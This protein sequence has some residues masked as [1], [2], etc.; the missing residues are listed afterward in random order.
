M[1]SLTAYSFHGGIE[2]WDGIT[3][4]YLDADQ[5]TI[6]LKEVDVMG[7]SLKLS[8]LLQPSSDDHWDLKVNTTLNLKT[9]TE[10]R[11]Y[12][13]AYIEKGQASEDAQP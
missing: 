5:V 10:L 11:D 8:L 6:E 7:P 9:A 3:K 2:P 13:T 1:N 12:L 4:E